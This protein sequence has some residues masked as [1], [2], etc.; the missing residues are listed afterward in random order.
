MRSA[1]TRDARASTLRWIYE[2][3]WHIGSGGNVADRVDAMYAK[4]QDIFSSN[5]QLRIYM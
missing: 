3:L 5:G 1:F 2:F 4:G